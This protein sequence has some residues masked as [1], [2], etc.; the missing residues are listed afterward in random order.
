MSDESPMLVTMSW[1][2]PVMIAG[3]MVEWIFSPGRAEVPRHQG[4]P[5]RGGIGWMPF[6]LDRCAQVVEKHRYWIEKGDVKHDS[7]S[8]H[9]QVMEDAGVDLE[10]FSVMDTFREH[11]YGC[12]IDD[13][14]GVKSLDVIGVDN[15]MIETDYPHSD[16]T[17]PNCLEHATKQLESLSDVDRYKILRGNA[18]RLFRFTPGGGSHHMRKCDRSGRRSED[19]RHAE[20][21]LRRDERMKISLFLGFQ[22]GDWIRNDS[23]GFGGS[24]DHQ[25][26]AGLRGQHLHRRPARAAR[27]R[28]PLPGGAPRLAVPHDEQSPGH[29]L[30]HGG[31]DRTTRNGHVRRRPALEQPAPGGRGALGPRQL[32]PRAPDLHRRRPRELPERVPLS[33]HRSER[34]QRAIQGG[35]RHPPA[36]APPGERLLR[37][38]ALPRERGDHPSEATVGRRWARR[39]TGP[40]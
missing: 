19:H 5:G 12:F 38:D 32:A 15:V 39:S 20:S 36:R 22:G 11:I 23:P 24:P 10:G 34:S 2:P 30:L 33:G 21:G 13:L 18:E 1:G 16:S 31:P 7:L 6:F 25:G 28:R 26:R 3:A 35:C 40:W 27:V 4:R 8:G 17:W 37:G 9:V 14:H 29:P